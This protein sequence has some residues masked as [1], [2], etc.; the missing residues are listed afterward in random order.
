[1]EL[2]IFIVIIVL[3]FKPHIDYDDENQTC[4]L[5]YTTLKNKRKYIKLW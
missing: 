2:I 4:F 1:M 5:W 3:I